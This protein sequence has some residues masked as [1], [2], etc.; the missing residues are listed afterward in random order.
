MGKYRISE[1]N[2]E[3]NT[4]SSTF[5][6][7]AKKYEENFECKPNLTLSVS[8]DLILQIMEENEGITSDVIENSYLACI[9]SRNLFDF[10]GVPVHS[11]AVDNKG[12]AVLFASPLQNCDILSYLDIDKVFC[13]DYP[14]IR[15]LGD[16]FY[17]YDT[18]F[19]EHGKFS[20]HKK[21]KLSSIVFVDSDK[22]DTLK[23]LEP[24]DFVNMFTRAVIQNTKSERMKHT[25]FMLEK[26]NK[27]INFFGVSDLNDIDFILERV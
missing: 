10:N 24:K 25:L 19:G 26:L 23:K 27:R 2:I 16:T 12:E 13:I 8:R 21:L 9:Y 11:V 22:F 18:P 17:V 5:L 15:L 7:N 3:I 4:E 20:K 14:G 6:D 1:L